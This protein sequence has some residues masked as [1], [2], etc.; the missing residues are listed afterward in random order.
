M[1]T[2]KTIKQVLTV[3]GATFLILAAGNAL[4]AISG[5]SCVECHTM[6]NSQD[7]ASMQFDSGAEPSASLLRAASCSG[8]HAIP[9]R[10]NS[11]TEPIPQVDGQ[12]YGTDTLAG[13]S[14]Y[15][16]NSADAN[17]HN[18]I[19]FGAAEDTALG[20]TPPGWDYNLDGAVNT[21]ASWTQQLTCSGTYGCHGTHDTVDT[22]GAISGAHHQPG[23]ID[24][25]TVGNSYRFLDGIM[26][27]ED[28]DWEFTTSDTDHNVYK[29]VARIQT[30]NTSDQSTISF[31]CAQCHGK[32]HTAADIDNTAG[33]NQMSSPWLRHPTDID[34]RDVGGE[35]A[36]YT[37]N[38]EAPAALSTMPADIASADY[39]SEAI[40][41]CISCHRAHGS[42]YADLLRW[43]YDGMSA[44]TT[45]DAA[46][47]GC[48]RCHTTKDGI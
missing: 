10:A 26:G 22:F 17:A 36:D 45:G 5:T 8:C 7:N 31:L 23:D 30:T 43:D 32:F 14:F 1:K 48:F 38:V 44:G 47:T 11:P 35:Y 18:V 28:P 21:E 42:P 13:G 34:L 37:F 15:F 25:T 33:P 3:V 40:V 20:L 19:D 6:H 29:G 4:A 41:T 12:N 46:G 16:V 24:G 2:Q 9:G 39:S 27:L